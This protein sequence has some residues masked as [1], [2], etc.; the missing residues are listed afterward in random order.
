M[1]LPQLIALI[2][3]HAWLAV[4]ILCVGF[5]VRLTAKDSKFPV[6][7]PEAWQPVLVL[8]LGTLA[9]VLQEVSSG[10]PWKAAVN[11]ALVIALAVLVAKAY[12][13]G[14]EPA[15]LKW[16]ALV[17]QKPIAVSTVVV[18]EKPDGPPTAA[19]VTVTGEDVQPVLDAVSDATD[20][21]KKDPAQ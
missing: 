20:P 12:Y 5:L 11:P 7:I 16:L 15:W 18:S 17:V 14:N 1:D 13:H 9:D 10:K 21:P 8:A 2:E 4:A 19:Q 6:N 3:S